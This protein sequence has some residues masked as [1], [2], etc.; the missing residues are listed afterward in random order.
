MSPLAG[1]V[2]LGVYAVLLA[3]GGAVGYL[4]AKSRPSLIAGSA[5]AVV[6]LAAVA[7]SYTNLRLG[8]FVGLVLGACLSWLFFV[9][10]R[11]SRKFMPSGLLAAISLIVVATM[12]VLL[13][14]NSS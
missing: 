7:V 2:V 12:V 8:F 5:S 11:R 4:K 6:A 10:Y 14:T 13:A 9:C 3:A 1:Q